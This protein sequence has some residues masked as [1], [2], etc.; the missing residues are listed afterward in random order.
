MKTGKLY[1]YCRSVALMVLWT[2]VPFGF[3]AYAAVVAQTDF[4]PYV[5]PGDSIPWDLNSVVQEGISGNVLSTTAAYSGDGKNYRSGTGGKLDYVYCVTNN[6]STL[7]PDYL[8]T[9]EYMCV[10]QYAGTMESMTSFFNYKVSGMKVGTTFTITVEYYALNST[11]TVGNP[12]GFK[13]SINP[14]SYGSSVYDTDIGNAGNVSTTATQRKQ[15]VKITGTVQTKDMDISF[16][17]PYSGKEKGY[18]I[19]ITK[20]TVEGTF[21]PHISSSQGLEACKGEQTLLSLD[22]EYNAKTYSWQRRDGGSWKEIGTS[23]SLLYEMKEDEVFRCLVDGTP[24]NELEVKSIMCCEVNGKPA[25]R[26]TLLWETFGHFTG[27]HTYVDR[28]GNVSTTPS[29][30]PV[31]RADVS[32]DLPGNTFDDGSGSKCKDCKSGQSA[33]GQINDGFYAIITPTPTGYYTTQDANQNANWMRAVTT[34]H[35]SLITGESNG[36]ALFI[37]VDYFFTGVVFEA[38]FPDVCTGKDVFFETWIANLSGGTSTNPIVTVRVIDSQDGTLL[39]EMADV[40]AKNNGGW[41][42]IKGQFLLDGSG[43]RSVKIQVLS[44]NGSNSMNNDSYWRDG[45]DLILDDIKFMVCSPPSLEAYSDISTFAKDSTICSD[46]DFTIDAPVSAMLENFFGGLHKFLFQY[47]GDEGKTWKNIS[48]LE[49]H[50]EFTINTKDYAEDKMQFRVVV[51]TPDVLDEFVSNPN[52]ADYEDAC[53]NY[54]ITEPFTITRSGDL[55][56]GATFQTSACVEDEVLLNAPSSLD[57]KEVVA[58]GWSDGDGKPV[59]ALSDDKGNLSYTIAHKS[60]EKEIYYFLAQTAAGCQG[61]RKYEIDVKKKVEFEYEKQEECGVTTFSIKSK[62]PDDATFVWSYNGDDFTGD[63]FVYDESLLP[64]NESP[65]KTK[66]VLLSGTATG[67]CDNSDNAYQFILKPIPGEP[68]VT[69]PSLS[70]V[71]EAGSVASVAG[72][73]V[74]ETDH[75]LE[76][77]ETDETTSQ[78]PASGWSSDEPFVSRDVDS[79]YYF[80]VRQ[81]NEFGCEGPAVKVHVTVS[82]SPLPVVLDTVVCQ[83]SPVDLNDLVSTTDDIYKLLWYDKKVTPDGNGSETAMDVKTDEPGVYEYYVTQKSTVSPY[84]ESKLQ[85]V[86]VTVVGVEKPDTTGNTYHYCSGD[87]AMALVA[88]EK[89]DESKSFYADEMV[90]SVDGGSESTTTPKVDTDVKKTT[91]YEYK[92]YQTYTI[93]NKNQEVCKGEPVSWEVEVTYVPALETSQVTY[94]KA[95][96]ENGTFDKNLMEQS[97]NEAITDYAS[98]LKLWWYEDDCETKVGNGKTAPTPKVDPAVAAGNDQELSYCV[99]Q[100]VDGC[101]SEGTLVP[102]LIS[103]APK[104][105]P[106]DYVY[107]KGDASDKLTTKPDMTIKP[108]AT[109]VLKWYGNGDRGNYTDLHLSGDEGPAPTTN[110]RAGDI[111]KSEYYYYVTQ[112]EMVNGQEGA[113]SNKTEIKVTVY[114]QTEI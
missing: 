99:K 32:Y 48:G 29:T 13:L 72:A 106:T 41:L 15:T 59:V 21:D 107:C 57:F 65:T 85:T 28:D 56:L 43:T 39:Y 20:I 104:P 24:S 19:G 88:K 86:K 27:K 77:V 113:E 38:E 69:N 95:D 25:S 16:L 45:N 100:E 30:W 54:S 33:D 23:K 98:T 36:G 63:E 67:Y 10:V 34:D 91:K 92:V 80:F 94:M 53:R 96:A 1:Q 111:G 49:D 101:L 2:C 42:P 64:T 51:A 79:T 108:N 62:T 102:V 50:N 37:N 46:M 75:T 12:L 105:N 3:S 26:R 52:K 112:T 89:K 76:W 14:N 7:N 71:M 81:V 18:A 70:F 47:S 4:S 82:S 58:W 97:E 74:A 93:N 6:P 40:E 66:A 22:K 103:D 11:L 61:K 73:A 110:M 60:E 44:T 109:Y 5:Y 68:G 84:P 17:F 31:Y 8:E 55:D 78:A 114:D 9:D 87:K 35:T 90:W 83:N